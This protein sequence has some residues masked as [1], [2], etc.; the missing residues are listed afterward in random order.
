MTRSVSDNECRTV[1]IESAPVCRVVIATRTICEVVIENGSI[2]MV[3]IEKQL[4]CSLRGIATCRGVEI[5]KDLAPSSS[6]IESETQLPPPLT[7]P[8]L[9]PSFPRLWANIGRLNLLCTTRSSTKRVLFDLKV[10]KVL[11]NQLKK[12]DEGMLC[13][14]LYSQTH[15]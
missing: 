12:H 1:A 9:P 8:P 13:A 7:R 4:A 2:C 10:R 14:G 3:A 6:C 11:N 5:E 15:N